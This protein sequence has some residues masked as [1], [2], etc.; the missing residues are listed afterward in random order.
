MDMDDRGSMVDGFL[1]SEHH[2][3]SELSAVE[4]IDNDTLRAEEVDGDARPPLPI[5]LMVDYKRTWTTWD[6]VT[7][8]EINLQLRDN[9][10][11]VI[12]S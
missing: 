10:T 1:S 3:H 9:A 5:P 4:S 2:D 8:A 6:E 7:A 12:G 11:S